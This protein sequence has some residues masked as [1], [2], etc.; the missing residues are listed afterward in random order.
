MVH[1]YD[2]CIQEMVLVRRFIGCICKKHDVAAG[3]A[4]INDIYTTPNIICG[5]MESGKFVVVDGVL[6]QEY[7]LEIACVLDDD[8]CSDGG[9]SFKVRTI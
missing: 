5:E 6:L 9:G 2:T 7:E 1:A 4:R 8:W 3:G